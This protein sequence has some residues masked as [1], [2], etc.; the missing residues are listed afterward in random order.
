MKERA[1]KLKVLNKFPQ[2]QPQVQL[3]PA[4]HAS[5]SSLLCL[6]LQVRRRRRRK[7]GRGGGGVGGDLD[8]DICGGLGGRLSVRPRQPD[9][10]RA[11]RVR[12]SSAVSILGSVRV[13]TERAWGSQMQCMYWHSL[14]SLIHVV[15]L[16]DHRPSP[17]LIWNSPWWESNIRSLL[18]FWDSC[19]SSY[20]LPQS[21]ISKKIAS[22]PRSVNSKKFE[23]YKIVFACL[24][25]LKTRFL[26]ITLRAELGQAGSSRSNTRI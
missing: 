5:L 15:S 24:W 25:K 9:P 13:R 14:S 17:S 6:R 22:R 23:G 16:V 19:F 2:Y 20:F 3:G 10:I 18:G 7:R 12:F 21:D 11:S 4:P 26:S 1:Y 8:F